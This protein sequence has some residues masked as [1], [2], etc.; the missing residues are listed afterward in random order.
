M[1]SKGCYKITTFLKGC[2]CF[3]WK[4][5]V[6][7]IK[8]P[9][10]YY[11][12]SVTFWVSSHLFWKNCK[13]IVCLPHHPSR[14]LRVTYVLKT[15]SHNT[16]LICPSIFQIRSSLIAGLRSAMWPS[17]TGMASAISGARRIRILQ[18]LLNRWSRLN[19]TRGP[20]SLGRDFLTKLR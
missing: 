19:F 14:H 7:H 20:S 1:R 18:E 6:W 2:A 4:G 9:L 10:I 8:Y 16:L 17:I 15:C 12:Y 3:K 11:W 13:R 5:R